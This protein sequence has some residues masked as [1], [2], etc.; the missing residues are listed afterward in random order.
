MKK[1]TKKN[2]G[3]RLLGRRLAKELNDEQLHSI[4][5]G[6]TTCSCGGGD[7]CDQQMR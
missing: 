6:T 1:N 3:R 2:N 5:G 4:T 7:D